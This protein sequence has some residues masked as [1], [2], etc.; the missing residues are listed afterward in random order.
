[1][2]GLPDSLA[3]QQAASPAPDRMTMLARRLWDE[4]QP[5]KVGDP[6]DQYLS[7]RGLGQER[8]PVAL[9]LHPR[10]GYYERDAQG[11]SHKVAEYAAMLARVDGPD[12]RLVTLHRTYLESGRKARIADA[13][14]LLSVGVSGAAIRLFEPTDE[15]ILAE[16]IE[17][18]LAAQLLRNMPAWSA[19]NAGNLE[20]IGIPP[21]VCRVLIFA[22]NDADGDFDGE[23]SAFALAR[24]LRKEARTGVPREVEVWIPRKRGA[25]WA[26]VWWAVVSRLK[27]A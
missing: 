9:R 27:R 17:T 18:A 21:G 19:L 16:G 25:D 11:K 7:A 3:A 6:V 24:R 20:R 12:G 5:V 26:D 8:Y 14:K 10:L 23:A 4:A 2:G 13:R 1:V 15:L 22:D